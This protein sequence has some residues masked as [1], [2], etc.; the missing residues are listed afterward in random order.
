LLRDRSALLQNECMAID[1]NDLRFLVAVA[2][3]GSTLKAGTALRVSQT[4][5]AR[6]IAALEQAAGVRLF[7]RRTAGYALTAD[8]AALLEP[9][10]TVAAAA[11]QFEQAASSAARDVSGTVRLTTDVLLATTVLGPI[12][13]ELHDLHPDIRID[14]DSDHQLR[15]LGAGEADIALRSTTATTQPA[16]VVGRRLC[17]D[18]WTLYCSREYAAQHGVPRSIADMQGHTLIGGGAGALRVAYD[19][20]LRDAGLE[21]QVAMFQGSALG[22]L[23]AVRSGFGIAV[24]PCLVAEG[25]PDFIRCADNPPNP[26]RALWLLTHERVRHAPRVRTVIDFLYEGLKRRVHAHGLND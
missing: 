23:S 1:W 9:A 12:L 26:G 20:W 15:D 16:G 11:M 25:D 14:L 10:R 4:T 18:D 22:L 19:L 21:G 2:E 17:P 6:R 24:L 5:V 7:E 3:H 8:G 13:R